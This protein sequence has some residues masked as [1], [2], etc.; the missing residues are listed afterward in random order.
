MNFVLYADDTNI[1]VDKDEMA[2]QHKITLV[3]RQ[4]ELWLSN[5]DLIVNIDKTCVISFHPYQQK[6]TPLNHALHLGIM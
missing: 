4:L 2:L 3:M 1:L 5:N 6:I